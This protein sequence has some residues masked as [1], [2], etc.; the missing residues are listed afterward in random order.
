MWRQQKSLAMP[1]EIHDD[2]NYRNKLNTIMRYQ[3][4]K[5]VGSLL[6]TLSL[7]A[8]LVAPI[9]LAVNQSSPVLIALILLWPICVLLMSAVRLGGAPSWTPAIAFAVFFWVTTVPAWYWMIVIS[10]MLAYHINQNELPVMEKNLMQETK[11]K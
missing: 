3:T 8:S 6:G 5:L 10:T 2:E 1:N 4:T 9:A 11:L 7:L